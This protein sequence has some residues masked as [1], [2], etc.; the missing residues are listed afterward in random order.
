[1]LAQNDATYLRPMMVK[2]G[3]ADGSVS[4]KHPRPALQIIKTAPGTACFLFLPRAPLPTLVR[5]APFLLT[6]WP[7]TLTRLQ[8]FEIAFQASADS[9]H[10]DKCWHSTPLWA[11]AGG[12]IAEKVQEATKLAHEKNA[13]RRR[14]S[15]SCRKRKHPGLP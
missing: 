2:M 13:E 11:L 12:A 4:A 5:M 3:D 9:I 6:G 15:A 7:S 8:S 1:M 10:D 14:S